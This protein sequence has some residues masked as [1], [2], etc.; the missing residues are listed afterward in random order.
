MEE[1]KNPLGDHLV[2]NIN[3]KQQQLSTGAAVTVAIF[4]RRLR[5]KA[6][7]KKEAEKIAKTLE[8]HGESDLMA[9]ALKYSTLIDFPQQ[10]VQIRNY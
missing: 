5:E 7:E 10:K 2:K 1:S 9:A 8:H 4:D 6:K 3:E